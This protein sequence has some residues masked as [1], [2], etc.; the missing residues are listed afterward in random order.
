MPGKMAFAKPWLV[1]TTLRDGEQAT[2]VAF[3]RFKKLAIARMLVEAGVQE[4]EVGT[5]AMGDDELA[6]IRDIVELHLPCRLTAW[7]RATS[8]DIDLA[9]VSGV[10]AV[11]I[12]FPTSTVHLRA[13]KKNRSW[14]VQ[15]IRE[16][17]AYPSHG[18]RSIRLLTLTLN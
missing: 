10:D 7:C 1:D 18:L 6:S 11:H 2:G 15:Q 17:T 9:T 4:L 3:S 16:L 5:P 12:S 13:M 14:V 8:D